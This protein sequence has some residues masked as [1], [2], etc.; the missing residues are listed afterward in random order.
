MNDSKMTAK[1]KADEI[2]RCLWEKSVD[3]G[4]E[5][6]ACFKAIDSA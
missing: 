1:E 5:H 4:R 6:G 3:M 2:R